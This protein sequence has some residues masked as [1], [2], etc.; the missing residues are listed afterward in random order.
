MRSR[1]CMPQLLS[2]RAAT[3]EAC[4]P[5]ARAPQQEK[6]PQWESL[7]TATKSSPRSQQLEKAHTQQRRPNTAKLKKKKKKEK[8]NAIL[9]A[10]YW[11]LPLPVSFLLFESCHKFSSTSTS[12]AISFELFSPKPNCQHISSSNGLG[13]L[14]KHSFYIKI[15][16][17]S[18]YNL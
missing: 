5:R 3:T 4:T 8:F 11:S 18:S 10:Y 9:P 7:R 12:I 1:A 2:P 16:T 13:F 14:E 6:L 15:C 17:A